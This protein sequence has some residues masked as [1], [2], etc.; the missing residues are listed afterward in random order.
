MNG[1]RSKFLFSLV[2]VCLSFSFVST[3]SAQAPPAVQERIAAIKQ[4]LAKSK[5]TLQQYEWIET[6]TV[7][8]KGEQK[9]QIMDKCYYGMDGKVQKVPVLPPQ[10]GSS[11]KKEELQDYVKSAIALLQKYV[12]PDPTMIQRCV[13]LGKVSIQKMVP[14]ASATLAF[15]DFLLPGDNLSIALDLVKNNITGSNVNTYLDT[16]KDPVTVNVGFGSLLDGTTY[17]ANIV[18]NLPSK[19]LQL[20]VQTSGYR[21]AGS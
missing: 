20:E 17:P 6:T 21:K 9:A 3:A 13:D 8:L 1:K 11:K 18:L 14:G 16:Q 15:S 10:G 2:L 19:K 7:I 5:Q 12:P 4:S